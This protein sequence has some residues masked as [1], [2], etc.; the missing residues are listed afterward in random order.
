MAWRLDE[1]RHPS[2]APWGR[3]RAAARTPV[4]L[5]AMRD[6]PTPP[7]APAAGGGSGRTPV[8]G[9]RA[10]PAQRHGSSR[11]A[12]KQQAPTP[13]VAPGHGPL[14]LSRPCALGGEPA[15]HRPRRLT[16]QRPRLP[17]RTH[18]IAGAAW[19]RRRLPR[20]VRAGGAFPRCC[21]PSTLAGARPTAG[22]PAWRRRRQ[23]RRRRRRLL[24]APPPR[25]PPCPCPSRRAPPRMRSTRRG[26]A[27]TGRRPSGRQRRQATPPTTTGGRLGGGRGCV[28]LGV[29]EKR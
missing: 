15:F 20:R 16:L 14:S 21:R 3:T 25:G 22:L 27:S 9:G 29:V 11:C 2:D 19:P 17:P 26:R 23:R 6:R 28:R 1:V 10:T 12:C 7:T 18:P 24:A 13:T 8:G 4:L 5:E